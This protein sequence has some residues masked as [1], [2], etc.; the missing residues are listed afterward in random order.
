M[1]RILYVEEGPVVGGST[2]T[3]LH[4]LKRLDRSRIEPFVLFRYDVPARDA[5]AALGVETATWAA[6]GASGSPSPPPPLPARIPR[7]KLTA[8]Y[9]LLRSAKIYA[10]EQR[11]DA[12][13][14]SRW[15]RNRGFSLVHANN[16]VPFN[17]GALV[18]ARRCGVPA[19][20]HQRGFFRLTPLHRF[21]ARRVERFVCVSDAVRSRCLSE[22]LPPDKVRT[23]HDGIDLDAYRPRPRAI[24]EGTLV[25]WFARFERWKGCLTFVEAARAVLAADPRFRFVMAGAGPEEELVRRMVASDPVF[26]DRISL[27]GFRKDAAEIMS[28]CDVVVNSSIEPEPLSNTALEALALGIPAVVSDV[29]GN[30][31]IVEH[32]VNGFVFEHGRSESLA[33]ALLSLGAD[34]AL[35]ERFGEAG[36]LRAERLFDARRYADDLASLYME[37]LGG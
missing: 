34:S 24:S 20:S 33:S 30:P 35:R 13:L 5:F 8:P 27:P 21:L 10:T 25:G 3:L 32:G 2:H 15:I 1:H 36:R 6:I 23:I 18:A 7:I 22:G 29:G 12:S 4:A 19:V 28:R 9:R 26:G 14:L 31:E 16:A 17:I 37:I 11:A